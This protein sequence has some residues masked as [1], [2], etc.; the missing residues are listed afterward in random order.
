[1]VLKNPEFCEGKGDRI[2][3][4]INE[5]ITFMQQKGIAFDKSQTDKARFYN[6]QLKYGSEGAVAQEKLPHNYAELNSEISSETPKTS[7]EQPSLEEKSVKSCPDCP[8]KNW[9]DTELII[10]CPICNAKYLLA[11]SDDAHK[12]TEVI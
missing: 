2:V 11:H 8:P 4:Y 10:E 7:V 6:M 12:L 5:Y 9:K 1:M 3:D